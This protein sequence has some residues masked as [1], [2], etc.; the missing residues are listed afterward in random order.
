MGHLAV[1]TAGHEDRITSFT[2]G[3]V[4]YALD[5]PTTECSA[6]PSRSAGSVD[7][8]EAA[9]RWLRR[10]AATGTALRNTR[11]LLNAGWEITCKAQLH[12]L[13]RQWSVNCSGRICKS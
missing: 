1:A 10:S 5:A 12:A 7:A 11:I 6:L 3:G 9:I 2:L 13:R 4:P 8:A